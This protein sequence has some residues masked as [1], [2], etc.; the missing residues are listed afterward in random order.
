MLCKKSIYILAAVALLMAGTASA[1][2]LKNRVA[3]ICTDVSNTATAQEAGFIPCD[4]YQTGTSA[5][6]PEYVRLV[7]QTTAL[8]LD[9]ERL[10]TII[11]GIATNYN[12]IITAAT[13]WVYNPTT[14]NF[15]PRRYYT[16][17]DTLTNATMSGPVSLSPTLVW[18]GTSNRWERWG[19]VVPADNITN[20]TMDKPGIV[21]ANL[22]W[23][24]STGRW[25]RDRGDE[26]GSDAVVNTTIAPYRLTLGHIQLTDGAVWARDS[27]ETADGGAIAVTRTAAYRFSLGYVWD[28]TDWAPIGADANGDLTVN[29]TTTTP[30]YARLQDGDSTVLGDVLDAVADNLAL[31]LNWTAT[32]SVMMG[33]D[34][35]TL[36]MLR[37]GA[38]G[39][40]QVT[41]VA[42]RAGEDAGNDWR[43]VKKEETAVYNPAVTAGTAVDD[44]ADDV[45]CAST[46]VLNL[47]N[48]SVFVKNAGGGTGDALSDVDVQ[49]SYDG[50]NWSSETSTACDTLTSGNS[51]RCYKG[52]NESAAYVQV[53][54]TCG[55]G[56][57]TTVDCVIQG[58]K[59]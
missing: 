5:A 37:V 10:S 55:G 25:M 29:Q 28:G 47:P 19:T 32:A 44:S 57:D 13:S 4:W 11:A 36:D 54:A 26:A 43:K 45:V 21:N 50:T 34:G 39:E 22:F 23:D 51:A 14:G 9:V 58:N 38:S 56:D 15:I 7:D 6:T 24:L 31:T 42:I 53:I 40:L 59:N 16:P 20:D 12:A 48:W 41:D 35:S 27:G 17:A 3:P 46:Y 18:N 30:G 52:A 49:I 33:Y 2:Q 8:T 1:Q